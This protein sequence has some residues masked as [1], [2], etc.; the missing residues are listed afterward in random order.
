[1]TKEIAPEPEL[2]DCSAEKA[3]EASKDKATFVDVGVGEALSAILQDKGWDF[4]TEIQEKSLPFSL[5]GKDVAGFAQTGTGK[6][7]AFLITFAEAFLKQRETI[8]KDSEKPFGLILCPT[9][10][11]AIQIEDEAKTLFDS[12]GLKT[13]AL[14]GGASIEVQ[15]QKLEEGVGLVAS[16]PGRLL[17]LHEQ[18][19]LKLD[20]IKLFICDEVDR[21]FDMGFSRDVESIMGK[22]P[23]KVQKLAFSATLDERA[24]ELCSHHLDNPEF[25]SLNETDLAPEQIKQNAIICESQDK[26]KLLLSCLREH[27][28]ICA[29]VFANTKLVTSWL[30]HKLEN[31]NFNAEMISGDLPQNKRTKL[32]EKIK[33]GDVK[34][35]IATDVASRGLHIPNVT[36]VYNFDM[37]DDPANYIHRIGRTARAGA[38]GASYSFVCEDYAQNFELVQKL[39]GDKAPVATVLDKSTIEAV[40]DLAQKP[41]GEEQKTSRP[42]RFPSQDDNRRSFSSDRKPF[43]K[44]DRGSRDSFSK[45]NRGPRD[46]FS[47]TDKG[48]RD[49]SSKKFSSP[50]KGKAE[51]TYTKRKASQGKFKPKSK[52]SKGLIGKVFG[53]IFGKK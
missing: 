17:D 2:L 48:P 21:M 20:E 6:T 13:T 14:Y 30:L 8:G 50:Q 27:E 16:T 12:L 36:H 25:V 11:L 26:I 49:N 51:G 35:L 23:S 3:Q 9:R 42:V 18:G 52:S 38:S 34:I 33:Q 47:K 24:K 40:E 39:L 53:A 31:N 45:S 46:S 1:M 4:P 5:K 15:S 41:F 43:Q 7:G 29:L 32:I 37:P 28:P 10:E 22:L 44:F 19:I